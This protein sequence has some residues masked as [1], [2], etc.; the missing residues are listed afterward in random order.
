MLTNFVVVTLIYISSQNLLNSLPTAYFTFLLGCLINS[1]SEL[2]ELVIQPLK[3]TA[4]HVIFQLL[5]PCIV[6]YVLY[7]EILMTLIILL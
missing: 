3:N 4:I 7:F 6:S 5:K 2:H 1:Q